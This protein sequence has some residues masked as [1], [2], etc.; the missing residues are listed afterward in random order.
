MD[1]ILPVNFTSLRLEHP[2]NIS[3]PVVLRISLFISNDV[4]PL[5]FSNAR[6]PIVSTLPG[7]TILVKLLQ[8]VNAESSILFNPAGNTICFNELHPPNALK[9]ISF[10]VSGSS[11][12]SK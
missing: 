7:T 12:F 1:F 6:P 9:S 2:E 8:P 10:T 3:D 4:S 11:T 5:Q